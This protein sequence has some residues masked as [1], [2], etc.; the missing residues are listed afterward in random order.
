MQN[1][2]AGE[3]FLVHEKLNGPKDG[4]GGRSYPALAGWLGDLELPGAVIPKDPQ[5]LWLS[6]TVWSCR[7]RRV[8]L[9]STLPL[10]V[11][12]I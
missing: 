11:C 12:S 3:K 4:S 5:Q 2:T 7:L 6:I 9:V 10:A 8:W 1:K